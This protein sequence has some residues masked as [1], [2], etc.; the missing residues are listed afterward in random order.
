[1]RILCLHGYG[2]NGEFFRMR[3]GALRKALKAEYHF[4][5]APFAA[6]ASFITDD[7]DGANGRGPALGWWDFEGDRAATSYR[8]IGLERTL[9]EVRQ[10]IE[11]EG[12]FDGIL[13]FSQG[14]TLAALLC[15]TPP[16]PPPVSF[17]VIVA[18]F[19][20]RDL[21]YQLPATSTDPP[22]LHVRAP[23]DAEAE[24]PR[25]CPETFIACQSPDAYLATR[26]TDH[27]RIRSARADG[28]ERRRG[29]LLQR[30]ADNHPP[31]RARRNRRGARAQRP[32]GLC[33]GGAR[34]SR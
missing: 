34:R 21:S 7:A 28:E 18:A 1:M 16:G 3:T 5:D 31:G 33:R 32:Q 19:P 29:R 26:R 4:M 2:Q 13:G 17:V 22:T 27:G 30:T 14:A 24:R 15:K 25:P 11:T 10:T 9:Q 12:P 23:S 8:Y 6:R 20:P